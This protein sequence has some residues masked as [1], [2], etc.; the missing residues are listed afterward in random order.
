MPAIMNQAS[1]TFNVDKVDGVS[2]RHKVYISRTEG[3][4]WIE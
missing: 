1:R 2:R 3:L 4:V